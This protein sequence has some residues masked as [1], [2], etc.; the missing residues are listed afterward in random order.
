MAVAVELLVDV[1]AA[2]AVAT[3]WAEMVA[4]V[5]ALMARAALGMEAGAT[6]G[7]EVAEA[8][9]VEAAMVQ[10][11]MVKEMAARAVGAGVVAMEVVRARI[12]CT[13]GRLSSPQIVGS[14][15]G[16]CSSTW[17]DAAPHQRAGRTVLSAVRRILQRSL[18]N[19]DRQH[20]WPCR[21]MAPR[22]TPSQCVFRDL[23]ARRTYGHGM[24]CTGISSNPHTLR[25]ASPRA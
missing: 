21:R 15:F 17:C 22:G 20:S 6:V 24:F 10:V 12:E 3:A 9:T 23:F 8:G 25:A 1:A 5:A 13:L 2:E 14:G 11:L 7:V 16:F 18:N 4:A 19:Q